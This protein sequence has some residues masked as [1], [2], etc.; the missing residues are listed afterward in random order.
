MEYGEPTRLHVKKRA[1]TEDRDTSATW[2]AIGAKIWNAPCAE[3]HLDEVAR[4]HFLT[5]HLIAV[6]MIASPIEGAHLLVQDAFIH[7]GAADIFAALKTGGLE[8]ARRVVEAMPVGMRKT[9]LRE[10]MAHLFQW[11]TALRSDVYARYPSGS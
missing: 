10:C 3:E 9:A 8:A 2:R 5:T 1:P 7:A 4:D 11:W 6:S